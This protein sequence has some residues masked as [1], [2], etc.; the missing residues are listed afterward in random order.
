MNGEEL[1]E[2]LRTEMAVTTRPPSLSVDA[3]LRTGRRARVRRRAAW[4]GVGLTAALLAVTGVGAVGA[5][6]SDGFTPA[7][8]GVGPVGPPSVHDTKPAWPTGPDGRPQ[9]DR[10]ARAGTRYDQAVRLLDELVAVVPAG[11]TVPADPANP[12]AGQPLLRDHQ[13]QFDDRVNGVEVWSYTSSLALQQGQRMGRLLVEVHSAGNPLPTEPCAL[14]RQF[15]GMPGECEVVTVGAT[16]VG[17]V[18]RPG[19]DDRFDQWAAYRHP[20]G[21]VVFVAQSR[22]LGDGQPGLTDLPFPVA[23]LA[24]LAADDRFHLG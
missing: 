13:A 19:A 1:R 18:V 5:P 4:A 14:A 15:W 12:P 2:A 10:T 24:A 7:A 20:D 11:Y 22:R 3:A 6:G 16:Q 17:V 8:P 21:V 23:R 9:E